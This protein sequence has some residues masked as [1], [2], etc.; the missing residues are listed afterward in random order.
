MK[1]HVSALMDGELDESSEGRCLQ[2]LKQ[3]SESRESWDL[4]HLIGDALR[5]HTT[6]SLPRSFDERLAEEPTVLAPQRK[7]HHKRH[8]PVWMGLSVAASVAAVA[9]VGWM[10]LPF[11]GPSPEQRAQT[12]ASVPAPA[13]NV[14][15]PASAEDRSQQN[16]VMQVSAGM[17]D[18]ILAH[19]RFSS[20]AAMAGVAP[21]ARRVNEDSNR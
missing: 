10:A 21:Y 17:N 18:Y 2:V 9:Y 7:T 12:V 4:Y 11:Y 5:G 8:H 16:G 15:L 6:G 20:S 1:E 13:V 19:Q 3:D 14:V